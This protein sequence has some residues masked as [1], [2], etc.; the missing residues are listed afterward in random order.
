MTT[1]SV[2]SPEFFGLERGTQEYVQFLA[3]EPVGPAN[4]SDAN[5]DAPVVPHRLTG[6]AAVAAMKGVNLEV[7]NS[8][9][10]STARAYTPGQGNR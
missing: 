3:E 8:T 6:L 2:N 5:F 7:T 10:G 1:P 4:S 9:F